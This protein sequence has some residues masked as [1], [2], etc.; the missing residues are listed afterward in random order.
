MLSPALLTMDTLVEKLQKANWA[1]HNDQPIMSDDEYDRGLEELRRL[2]PSHPFLAMIGAP[3]SKGVVLPFI[4]GSQDKARTAEEIG[5]WMKRQVSKKVI[6]S[7]KL[8]GLSALYTGKRLYLRGDGVKGIDVSSLIGVLKLGSSELL[9]GLAIR[10]ELLLRKADT[11]QGSIGRSLVNGWVHKSL[12]GVLSPELSKVRFVAYQVLGCGGC[13]SCELMSRSQQMKWLTEKGFEV[14]WWAS[15]PAAAIVEKFLKAS[16]MCRR[17]DCEYP[18]DGLVLASDAVPLTVGGGE[19]RN[20]PDSIAFKMPLDDQKAET[21]VIGVEWNV[22]RHGMLIP[23]IQVEMVEIGG[24]KIQWLSGHNAGLI[25]ENKI[26]PG[27]KIIVR[28]SGDVIPALDSVV[29]PAPGGAQMPTGEWSWDDTGVQ[30]VAEADSPEK[31]ILHAL[32]TLGVEGIGPGLVKKMVDGGFDTLLKIWNSSEAALGAI[33]GA[34]RAPA[35]L[36]SLKERL[37]SASPS[38]LLVASNL[39]PRGVGERK[40]RVLFD[41]EPDPAKWGAIRAG[42]SS[43]SLKELLAVLPDALEWGKKFP[44][45]PAPAPAPAPKEKAKARKF[46]VFTGVRDK[47]LESIIDNL[48][49]TEPAITKKTNLLVTADDAKES[50]KVK[51]AKENGLAIMTISE[52]R[53]SYQTM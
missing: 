18:I 14:P 34:G 7:E 9:G 44:R 27:A 25:S 11:P 13:G 41:A 46:V 1:Y 37:A 24:A 21:N 3:V 20:P 43:E 35:L 32:Q 6:V 4:M 2:S 29:I 39:L 33:I 8:D 50:G 38:V 10:G 12:D 48:W 36:A 15:W 16:L 45:A 40:L 22:S 49:E 28:R 23:R 52:F 51:K 19:A 30:A 47:V 53:R 42:W 26:G 31:A 17:T 5:R